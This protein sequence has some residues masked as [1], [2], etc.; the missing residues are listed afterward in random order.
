[1]PSES[2]DDA[3]FTDVRWDE[4]SND[5]PPLLDPPTAG[6]LAGLAAVAALLAYDLLEP[7]SPLGFVDWDVSRMDWLVLFASVLLVRYGGYPLVRD[8]ERTVRGLRSLLRRPAGALALSF[9]LTS[10]ALA[11]VGPELVDFGYPQLDHKLQPPVFASVYV[12]DVYAYNCVGQVTD[13]YCHGTWQYPLGTDRFGDGLIELLFYGNRVAVKLGLTT[14]VVMGV[15]ATAVGTTAGY[16]GG[17]VDDALS[18]YL[19]VQQTIPAVVVYVVLATLF[20]GNM[21]GVSDGGLFALAV[22][23]GLLDWGGI[24]RLVRSDVVTRRSTG[25]VRAARAAGAGNLYT[26]RRHVVPN[27]MSTVVTALSRRIP[28]LVLAQ[29]GLAYLELNRAGSRSLG[30]VLRLGVHSRTNNL[31]WHEKWWVTTFAVLFL[32]AFVLAYGVF[33][34]VLRDVLDPREG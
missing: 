5:G 11:V 15:V 26:I 25:Y 24:A 13:G 12:E 2:V 34:D 3:E 6:L 20:L 8:R 21:E 10:L 7:G 29:V 9:L 22:V 4:L 18:G 19:D 31:P 17:L 23:F 33:G 32:V 28:L 30:R 27:A 16:V 14:A 1:M